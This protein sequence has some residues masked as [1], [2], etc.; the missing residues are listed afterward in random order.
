[1]GVVAVSPWI[2]DLCVDRYAVDPRRIRVFPNGVD[3]ERFEPMDRGRARAILGL[4]QDRPV[5]VFVGHFIERKGPLRV[6]EAIRAHPE[7][8]AV[9]IGDG[10]QRPSG[11]QVLFAG[12]VAHD[13]IPTWLSAGDVFALPTLEEGS[14]NA[15]I[16]AMACGRAVI[17]SDIPSIRDL[18]GP[19]AARLV[20]PHDV[21]ALSE[22]IATL[23]AQESRRDELARRAR[24][25]SRLFSLETRARGILDWLETIAAA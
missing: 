9:F 6:L 18:T 3:L 2:H 15:V 23:L 20:D 11:P 22:A 10:P 25:R 13:E 24:D 1:D 16:E 12:S 17:T 4:P 7:A 19:D 14:C 5:V 8:G 21:T